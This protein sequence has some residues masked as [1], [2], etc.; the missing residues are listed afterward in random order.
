[1]ANDVRA[2]DP[3]PVENG[4]DV[5]KAAAYRIVLD[6]LGPIRLTEPA[7]VGRHD[8]HTGAGQSRHLIAPQSRGVRK[9]VKEQDRRPFPLVLHRQRQTVTPEPDQ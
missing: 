5:G 4:N 3:K 7:Q 1:M 9:T 2:A 8:T 6:R